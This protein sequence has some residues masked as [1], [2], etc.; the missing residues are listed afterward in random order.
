MKKVALGLLFLVAAASTTV[1]GVIQEERP[2]LDHLKAYNLEY[3][4]LT[5]KR[6]KLA[7]RVGELKWANDQLEKQIRVYNAKRIDLNR[8]VDSHLRAIRDH[9]SRCAGTFDDPGYVDTCNSE[10]HQLNATTRTQNEENDS[11]NHTRDLLQTA[12]KTQNEEVDKAVVADQA[13]IDRQ[14]VIAKLAQPIMERLK[15]LSNS[16]DLCEKAIA[17]VDINPTNMFKKER[18]HDVCGEMFDGN[19]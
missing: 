13:A 17:A 11:L 14:N 19:K 6:A 2:L 18:M 5:A 15:I 12:I 3:N 10:A 16:N 4:Q 9:D 1:A 8:R 7:K